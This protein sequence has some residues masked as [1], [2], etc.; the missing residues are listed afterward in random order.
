MRDL[1]EGCGLEAYLNYG[2]LLGAVRD[3]AMIAHDSDTDVCYLSQHGRR[4][5]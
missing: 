4:G 1:T 3:G 5:T 2:A